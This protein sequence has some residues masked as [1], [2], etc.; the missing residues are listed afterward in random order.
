M[1][2]RQAFMLKALASAKG[3]PDNA[4]GDYMN[5]SQ[6]T[7]VDQQNQ[8]IRLLQIQLSITQRENAELKNRLSEQQDK[9]D[10]VVN[11]G[12]G[13]NAFK[14]QLDKLIK[15]RVIQLVEATDKTAAKINQKPAQAYA[16]APVDEN[17]PNIVKLLK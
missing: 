17:T 4:F 3:R 8:E 12:S 6:N 1:I 15:E 7:L 2:T 14:R 10:V 11:E 5:K 13:D 16:D 9:I